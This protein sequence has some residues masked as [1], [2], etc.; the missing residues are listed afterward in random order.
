MAGYFETDKELDFLQSERAMLNEAGVFSLA[1]QGNP[2]AMTI[3]P[4]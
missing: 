3:F 4:D 2:V 1:F